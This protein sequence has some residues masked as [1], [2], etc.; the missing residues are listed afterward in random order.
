MTSEVTQS[1]LEYLSCFGWQV[2]DE[3]KQRLEHIAT[4]TD[5]ENPSSGQDW[6]NVGV[7]ALMQAQE[8]DD[9]SMKASLIELAQEAFSEGE[10]D[11]PLCK[12]HNLL[13]KVLV[14][15]FQ[16]ARQQAFASLLQLQIEL[17]S[18]VSAYVPLGLVYFPVEWYSREIDREQGMSLLYTSPKNGIEQAYQYLNQVFVRSAPIFYNPIGLHTL[19][20]AAQIAPSLTAVHLK[21]GIACRMAGQFE[22]FIYLHNALRL[23]PANSTVLQSLALA[24]RDI[25]Q[26]A[27]FH[28]YW[29]Q[30][31]QYLQKDTDSADLWTQAEPTAA[32]TYVPFDRGVTLAVQPSLKSIVT[33]VLLGEGDW[34]ESEMEFWRDWLKPGM[35]VI[36]VGAN[37]G[38]Y[39]FSA[40]TQVGSKGKV[41]AIEPF[42]ACV[43]Y[44]EETC[45][46][47]QFDW[48]RVYGAAASE[49][50]GNVRLSIQGASEL[51][52]VIADDAVSSSSAKYIEVPCLT[53][54]SLIEQEDL[55]SVDIMKLDAEGHEINVLKGCQSLLEKFQPVILYENI[56]GGQ[57]NNLEVA[58]FLTRN[59]Y[60]LHIYQP[61]L[62]QLTSLTSMNELD[63][64][65]NIIAMPKS[66]N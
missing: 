61:Y 37:A 7:A 4:N 9:L 13:L 57:G 19:A 11:F 53:L 59:G 44:L 62:N 50:T 54:D 46:V 29:S 66:I 30:A 40:A 58:E 60:Q 12:A 63:G 5:W 1:Y 3:V 22:G 14:G 16:G 56:A 47:N 26:E 18:D 43:G 35:T 10:T 42:P 8:C 21:Q 27:I 17:E 51:N 23:A 48:V 65:L 64:Q 24:Y 28:N 39:T 49:R 45:R 31:K 52:E 36:D 55:Q 20:V 6:N 32:F 38:V 34:F 41:I 2:T 15:Q 25:G 33:S